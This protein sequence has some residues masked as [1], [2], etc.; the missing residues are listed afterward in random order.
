MPALRTKVVFI[1]GGSNAVA[2]LTTLR[3]AVFVAAT[4]A[5]S[6]V[7]AKVEAS[8]FSTLATLLAFP[9]VVF[10][11]ENAMVASVCAPLD[12]VAKAM[13]AFWTV[14]LAFSTT[15]AKSAF[16]A[17][18]LVAHKT[19]ATVNEVFGSGICHAGIA[20]G[21]VFAGIAPESLS[22]FAVDDKA[23]AAYRALQFAAVFAV[24]LYHVILA[25]ALYSALAKYLVTIAA[26][27]REGTT[28]DEFVG[29]IVADV[30]IVFVENALMIFAV[31]DAITAILAVMLTITIGVRVLRTRAAI[32]AEQICG[33]LFSLG[34][35]FCIDGVLG[36]A[37]STSGN[38]FAPSVGPFP[39][40]GMGM[41]QWE[42]HY[43]QRH[44]HS[45]DGLI[46][47]HICVVLW[48]IN[49]CMQR[50]KIFRAIPNFSLEKFINNVKKDILPL[51]AG[52][53]A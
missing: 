27:L 52:Y 38:G 37:L 3:L 19:F 4:L 1:V 17:D 5:K 36:A 2:M 32:V 43:G 13:T 23:N 9:F 39:V 46:L 49:F 31:V 44:N 15:F 24:M 10:A 16:R 33:S 51:Y 34:G 21:V 28:F 41:Q 30:F 42:H 6:A 45:R 25:V 11:T 8:A 22:V 14:L 20:D 50:Y 18:V 12:F 29:T 26:G 53:V 35:A 7:V 40:P 48:S 47:C